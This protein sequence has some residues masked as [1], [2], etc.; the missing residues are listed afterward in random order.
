MIT[1]EK[2]VIIG[3]GIAGHNV[4]STLRK[5][6]YDGK[7]TL[8]DKTKTLPYDRSKLSKSW[9][10]SSDNMKP[11]LFQKQAYFDKNKIEIKLDT[12]VVILN[13]D[14]KTIETDRGET[15]LFDKLVIATGST[16]RTLDLPGIEADGI[17]TLRFYEDAVKIKK[18]IE[19]HNVKNIA[20][21]GA[22]FIGLELAASFSELDL[23][24][25][26]I[27]FN[28]YPLAHVLGEEVAKYFMKM[29]KN[30]NIRFITKDSAV[31]FESDKKGRINKVITK[32]DQIVDCDM[33]IVGVGAIPNLS[34][35]H[36]KL[37]TKNGLI[38]VDEYGQTS[39]P[40][41]YAAGD[42]TLWPYQ[43]ELIHVEHWEHAYYH[44][45]AIAKN[46]LKSKSYIYKT[47]PYFWTDQY[48]Q[49]FER[50]GYA[51]EWDDIITRGSL[52]DQKF[53]QAYVDKD[54]KPLAI[55]FANNGD[56]RK[57]ISKLMDKNERIDEESFKDMDND[58]V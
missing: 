19:E 56:K 46:I 45:Q 23:Q 41:I 52:E 37:K 14:Q 16:S 38:E 43:G 30:H 9:M 25:T 27:E 48:D 28:E 58:L 18:W 42:I 7:I 11:P 47:R 54:K 4:V 39:I 2:V 12:E 31:S 50:L 13:P 22:G 29:H 44:G 21:I 10:Q 40:D 5:N 1:K 57:N 33:V 26:V 32:G 15:I 55:F 36:S 53:T 24:V 51:R 20:M 6:G 35:T 17:F 3:G 8:I 34:V 49:T